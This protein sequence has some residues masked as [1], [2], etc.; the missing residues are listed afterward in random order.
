MTLAAA[1][2]EHVRCNLCGADEAET[3]YVGSDPYGEDV[4]EAGSSGAGGSGRPARPRYRVARCRRCGLAY[5]DPR[6]PAPAIG[7]HYPTSFYLPRGAP[8]EGGAAGLEAAYQRHLFAWEMD[9]LLAAARAL[10]RAP[11]SVLDVGCGPGQ[12]LL[13]YRE[14]GLE[15]AGVEMSADAERARDLGLDVFRGTLGDYLASAGPRRFDLVTAYHVVEHLFDP[16]AELRAMRALVA[17]RGL[18]AIVVPNV[19]SLQARAFRGRWGPN[20]LP[21]HTYFF[22][23]RTLR[24]M[25]AAAG[26]EPLWL[27]TR[28]SFL[29]PPGLVVSLLPGLDPRLTWKGEQEGGRAGLIRRGLWG[30]ATLALAPAAWLEGLLGQGGIMTLLA[31]PRP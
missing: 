6:V 27:S 30:A 15:V 17:E 21:R 1:A 18:V 2:T 12:R 7:A 10:G 5:Q 22:T 8:G 14:R 19:G 29:H 4:A 31:A 24:A 26:Y 9:R 11:G 16:L 25:V 28:M 20:D 23:P 13:L 3:L